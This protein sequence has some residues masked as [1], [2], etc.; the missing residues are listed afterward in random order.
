MIPKDNECTIE[1]FPTPRRDPAYNFRIQSE[2]PNSIT[3]VHST[4]NMFNYF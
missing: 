4:R 3:V 2:K 1:L